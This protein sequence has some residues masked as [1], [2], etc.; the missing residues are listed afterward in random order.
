MSFKDTYIP[1]DG[2]LCAR[3]IASDRFEVTVW[4]GD[5]AQGG[6]HDQRTVSLVELNRFV[7]SQPFL[8]K[9]EDWE[10]YRPR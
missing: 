7:R 4:R 3:R 8:G 2:D 1:Q 10:Y 5:L 9:H 6:W